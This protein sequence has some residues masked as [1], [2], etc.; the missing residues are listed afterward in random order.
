M[1]GGVVPGVLPAHLAARVAPPG[2]PVAAARWRH[3][4]LHV[5]RRRLPRRRHRRHLPLQQHLGERAP[6]VLIY[7]PLVSAGRPFWSVKGP[8]DLDLG[9]SVFLLKQ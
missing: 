4:A 6:A 5:G 1:Q 7:S 3:G 8:V 9:C 2:G